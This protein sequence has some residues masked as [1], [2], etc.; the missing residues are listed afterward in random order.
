MNAAQRARRRTPNKTGLVLTAG[1]ARGAYQAGVLK[2]IGE[3]RALHSRPSP[4]PII[5]GASAGAINGAC[6]ASYSAEFRQGTELLAGLW[7]QLNAARVYRSDLWSLGKNGAGLLLD[8]LLG[9]A[10]GAGRVKSFVDTAPLRS[11]LAAAL[12]MHGI[13]ES[14]RKR[15]LYAL[16]ITATGYHSGKAFTFIQ[17]QPGHPLWNKS[18][19]VALRATL[20]A[21]HVYA[22]AAI[23]LVFPPAPLLVAGATAYFGD[24]ALR[25]V[26]PLSPAIRLGAGRVF[27]IGVRNT[28][29]ADD[30][31]RT[32]L[33]RDGDAASAGARLRSPPLA[34]VCGV[35][36]NAIFLDHLDADVDHLVRMNQLVAAQGHAGTDLIDPDR[37]THEPMRV[38]E[39]LVISPSEDLAIVARSLERHMPRSI[40]YLLDGL[41]TPDAQSADLTSYLLFDAAFTRELID[42]GYRDAARRIDEI[43][44][45]LLAPRSAALAYH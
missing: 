34:Q 39:P 14:I 4:F 32:E 45:F 29:A 18:R 41:G 16:A 28:S 43:E 44:A 6:V 13:A 3:I 35:F 23:P 27:A 24:G 12:P 37:S 30:L 7:A 33:A 17:G 9:H 15:H 11:F 36:L 40:R 42:I 22:S 8:L 2:R 26:T 20:T 25:L 5:A 21:D 31:L 10:F 1:G 19:R 38:V